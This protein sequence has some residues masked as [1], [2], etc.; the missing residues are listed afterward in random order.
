MFF[1]GAYTDNN[2]K[3]AGLVIVRKHLK[4]VKHHYHAVTAW[5]TA[6]SGLETTLATLYN[7]PSLIIKKRVFSQDRRPTKDVSAHPTIIMSSRPIDTA[8]CANLRHKHIPVEFISLTSTGDVTVETPGKAGVG[9][10]FTVPDTAIAVTLARVISQ[11]RYVADCE[12][13]LE[14]SEIINGVSGCLSGLAVDKSDLP[15]SSWPPALTALAAILWF[16]ENNRYTRTYRTSSIRK[17]RFG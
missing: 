1:I 9:R 11:E 2:A 4:N 15:V 3:S 6:L 14:R 8:I 12:L 7:D 5:E 17:R 16:R 10:D 13:A